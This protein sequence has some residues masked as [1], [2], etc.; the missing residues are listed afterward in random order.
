MKNLL[1]IGAGSAGEMIANEITQHTETSKKYNI[2]GFLDDDDTKWIGT[3]GG[4]MASFDGTNWVVYNKGN[5]GLPDNYVISIAIDN[6]GTK[7][8]ATGD[9]GLTAFNEDGI[10]VGIK[11]SPA[12][13]YKS[14][15]SIY[16]NPAS[17]NFSI[18]ITSGCL[19]IRNSNSHTL[20]NIPCLSAC[21]SW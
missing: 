20:R 7:W 4:G 6:F 5:S 21:T 12:R 3:W 18:D 17:S 14:S 8:I 1:I 11:E 19:W 10:P 13:Y 15:V 9:W 16:P 2:I